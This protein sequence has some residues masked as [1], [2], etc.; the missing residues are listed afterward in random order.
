MASENDELSERRLPSVRRPRP[1]SPR[2]APQG[3]HRRPQ[4]RSAL[5]QALVTALSFTLL[6]GVSAG[7]I[8]LYEYKKLSG[9]IRHVDALQTRD[10]NIKQAAK[11]VHAVNYLV[12]GSDSRAGKNSTAHSVEGERSDT[13]I[14]IHL[15]KNRQH[16]T[17]VSIPRVSWVS[18]PACTIISRDFGTIG[19]TLP[20]HKGQFN[21]AFSVGGAKCTIATVQKLTGVAV[22]HYLK[23][24]FVGFKAVVNALGSVTICSPQAVEDPNSKLHLVKGENKLNGVESLSYV[25]ARETLGDGSDLGRIKRQQQFL[26]IV[27]RKALSGAL[28]SNP[29]RLTDFL[30]AVTRAITTDPDTNIGDLRTLGS[31]MGGLDPKHVV[32]YTAPIA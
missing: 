24:D 14:L 19:K 11:Q 25:R 8:A 9:Q 18:I 30:D 32:F 5:R 28:L 2:P 17:V 29:V 23:L 4:T 1:G 12:I 21:S 22:T 6:L 31:S 16:V 27:L 15:S 20:E 3:R 7:G 10:P 13:T 26:G